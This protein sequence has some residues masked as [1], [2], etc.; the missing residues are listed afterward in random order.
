MLSET[1]LAKLAEWTA[2]RD[3]RQILIV[4]DEAAGWT[5]SLMV[6]RHDDLSCAVWE[7]TLQR[8]K[9]AS[10]DDSLE[11]WAKRAAS[12]ISG[13]P[14]ALHVYEVDAQR[15]E[16]L[17]RSAP[18]RRKGAVHYYEVLLKGTKAA[19]VRRFKGSPGQGKRAQVAFVLTHE[20]L[21]KFTADLAAD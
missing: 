9:P 15:N 3:G 17:L 21:A 16:A 4:P 8:T 20:Q 7:I 13:T 12:R 1:L 5:V 18:A 14:E 11:K 2:P 19:T 6:D 10:A